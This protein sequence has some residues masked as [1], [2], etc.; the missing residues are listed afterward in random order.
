MSYYKRNYFIL[1]FFLFTI[2]SF[3]QEKEE[4]LNEL[5]TVYKNQITAF[6]FCGYTVET[7]LKFGVTGIYQFKVPKATLATRPSNITLFGYY[8]IE[9][10]M[11]IKL[12]H[13]VFTKN[14]DWLLE[15]AWEYVI[16]PEKY[17]GIGA[18]TPNSN[19]QIINWTKVDFRQQV[20][21]KVSYKMFL[22]L[23]YRYA[24]YWD[25]S[26]T[27]RKDG[28][29]SDMSEI[30]GYAGGSMSGFGF[31]YKWDKRDYVM[32]PTNG[33]FIEAK[34]EAYET[35]MGSEY[36][37]RRFF[38][39]VR[40]YFD[41]TREKEGNTVLA[42]QSILQTT[43]GNVPFREMSLMGGM[44]MMR[45]IYEGRYR[46]NNMLAVQA[47]LRQ[48]LFWR[49]G[50]TGF[51]STANVYNQMNG[52]QFDQTK[53]AGGAGLRFIFNKKDKAS[54]RADYGFGPN[55]SSGLYLTYGEAF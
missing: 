43:N 18:E 13:T 34:L 30:P 49:I 33:H 51:V 10:Q 3:G 53:L 21:R 44:Y 40:K 16:F 22:G 47:E 35:W 15:G 1:L 50:M 54:L 17:Y 4:Y 42:L 45:G 5:D 28:T 37:F 25:I 46:D 19:E 55:K 8:T 6:P 48:H 20:L 36:S 27:K 7:R 29:Y 31:V 23:Q 41:L 2:N 24:D 9:N 12:A 52:F 38:L 14:E 26:V 32:A 11:R 39:D